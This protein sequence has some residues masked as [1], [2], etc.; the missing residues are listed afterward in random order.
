[1]VMSV[2]A[3]AGDRITTSE[4]CGDAKCMALTEG[5]P[6]TTSEEDGEAELPVVCDAGGD[7]CS[8]SA[9][10]EPPEG[11]DNAAGIRK[12]LTMML[13]MSPVRGCATPPFLIAMSVQYIRIS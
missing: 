3:L 9:L 2:V 11:E 1:M 5:D 12:G 7:G 6:I 4:V 10:A 13:R 8:L